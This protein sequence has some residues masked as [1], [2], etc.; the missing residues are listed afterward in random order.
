M[1]NNFLNKVLSRIF[2]IKSLDQ[3]TIFSISTTAKQEKN[4]Y[5]TPVR[6][7]KDF[8][9]TGCII[10]DQKNLHILLEKIDGEVDIILADSE[11]V[12]PMDVDG[13]NY[14]LNKKLLVREGRMLR[15]S[16]N[17]GVKRE[18]FIDSLINKTPNIRFDLYGMDNRQP[19]S[20]DDFINAISQSKMGINLSQGSPVKYYSSDRLA[21]LVGNGLLVL[22]DKK[23]QFTDFFTEKE[24]IFYKNINDLSEKILKYSRD[25]KERS[26]IAKRG[27]DKYFKYFNSSIIADYIIN[28]TFEIKKN[29]YWDK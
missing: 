12:I 14:E 18:S 21:Q 6:I 23:T 24:L 29:Y 16:L 28:K 5:L 9:L 27:R 13:P 26:I 19:V 15:L 2:K 7:C 8:I 3:K 11:K 20:A 1:D 10:F 22:V 4:A 17:E 25:N